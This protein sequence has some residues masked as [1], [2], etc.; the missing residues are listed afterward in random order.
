MTAALSPTG[1]QRFRAHWAE[2][3][4]IAEINRLR[5]HYT[6]QRAFTGYGVPPSE[7]HAADCSAYVSLGCKWTV[8]KTGLWVRDPLDE[9]YSGWGNTGTLYH[10]L[11]GHETPEN[12]YLV[13]DIA[14]FGT[15]ALTEHTSVCRKAGTARTAIFSSNGHEYWAFKRDAPNPISLHDEAVQQHLIGVYRLPELQ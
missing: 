4:G 11:R 14:I 2:Y 3:C 8:L 13:G 1:K 9:D 7:R 6:K 5:W 10:Y 12:R 15:P